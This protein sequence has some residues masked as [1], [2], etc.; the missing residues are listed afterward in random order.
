MGIGRGGEVAANSGFGKSGVIDLSASSFKGAGVLAAL[1]GGVPLTRFGSK[2]SAA[3]L[4][5][6][7]ETDVEPVSASFA[8]NSSAG[9]ASA[10]GAALDTRAQGWQNNTEA[11][12]AAISQN[13]PAAGSPTVAP[14]SVG[15]MPSIVGTPRYATGQGAVAAIDGATLI[16]AQ[17]ELSVFPPEP[18]AADA[19]GLADMLRM[20]YATAYTGMFAHAFAALDD[21]ALMATLGP[22]GGQFGIPAPSTALLASLGVAVGIGGLPPL[23]FSPD[24][25]ASLFVTDLDDALT[26]DDDK[27]ALQALLAMVDPNG[28]DELAV[29]Q[30]GLHDA[31]GTQPAVLLGAK[32]DYVFPIASLDSFAPGG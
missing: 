21:Q 32:L 11:M 19:I 9:L 18:N 2:H 8:M 14:V 6:L 22:G 24:D 28:A 26:G 3:R 10:R 16:A 23:L 27:A 17:P 12:A 4:T 25:N 29:T 7:A 30:A 5:A 13:M 20:Y 31:S 1:T 15:E